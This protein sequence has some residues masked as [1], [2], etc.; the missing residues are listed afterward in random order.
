MPTLA[1]RT[2][3][4]GVKP[5]RL[6]LVTSYRATFVRQPLPPVSPFISTLTSHSQRIENKAP[7][8]PFLA[9]LTS[10]VKPLLQKTQGGGCRPLRSP[11]TAQLLPT[12]P[13]SPAR[14]TE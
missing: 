5:S 2:P 4:L 8:S 3:C 10:Y 14:A 13:A 7:L 1:L 12:R 9:T 11:V 6:S